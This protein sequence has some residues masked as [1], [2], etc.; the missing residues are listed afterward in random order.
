LSYIAQTLGGVVVERAMLGRTTVGLILAATAALS[1]GLFGC[2]SDDSAVNIPDASTGSDDGGGSDSQ[3]TDGGPGSDGTSQSDTGGQPD[4]PALDTS[5]G[6]DGPASDTGSPPADTGADSTSPSGV[7]SFDHVYVIVMEN[8]SSTS[9][10]GASNA[11]YINSLMT[12]YV[13]ATKYSTAIHPSLPNYLALTSGS[14]QG[15]VGCDCLP[16][17]GGTCM[18]FVCLAFPCQCDVP[19]PTAGMAYHLGDQLEAIHVEWREY[20]QSATAPCDLMDHAPYAMKHVPFLYYDNVQMNTSRCAQRVRPFTDLAADLTAGTYRFSFISPDL[21]NDMHGD[22]SCPAGDIIAQ[23]DTWLSTN[24]PPILATAGFQPG[25]NDVLFIVWDEQDNST[26]TAPI[27]LVI[28]SPRG[29]PMSTTAVAYTHMSLLA[30]IEDA[31]GVSHLGM[32]AMPIN[33][34][35]Q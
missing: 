29:K 31:F 23:G 34:V 3:G 10:Q 20:A 7:P 27:P 35:W 24:V 6:G 26:G 22:P 8:H 32:A 4:G 13:N 33:D 30:T 18:A 12:K 2:S 21:C 14:I 1:A 16:N 25:G 15:N 19:T 28:I 17:G 9:I 5:M 11:P